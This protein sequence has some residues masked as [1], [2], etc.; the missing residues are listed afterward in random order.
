MGCKFR[1]E[2][3]KDKKTGEIIEINVPIYADINIKG[4]RITYSTGYRVD[5]SKWV[6]SKLKDDKTGEVV[7][8]QC[9]LPKSYGTRSG[10][11]VAA[12]IINADLEIIR[13]TV[14]NIIKTT[15]IEKI[16]AKL[17]ISEI[18]EQISK[19]KNN[20]SLEGEDSSFWGLFDKFIETN[21]V[22]EDR[23]RTYRNAYS[24]LRNFEKYSWR[25][26]ID[27]ADCTGAMMEAFDMFMQTD[28]NLNGRYDHLPVRQRPKAKSN[29]T[30]I[31]IMRVLSAFFKWLQRHHSITITA[32]NEYSIG[33]EVYEDPYFLTIDERDK[34]LALELTDAKLQVAQDI[35]KFQTFMGARISDLYDLRRDNITADGYIEFIADKTIIENPRTIRIPMRKEVK[36]VIEKYKDLPEDRLFPY[37]DKQTYN[38]LLRE[39][40]VKAGIMRKVSI[41]DKLTMK[42]EKKYIWEVF[43]SHK[44]RKTFIAACK[45]KGIPNSTIASMSGH[46]PNSK[47]FNRYFTVM[48]EQK[49][50]ALDMI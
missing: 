42:E 35:F 32:F 2:K 4:L 5:S 47:A 21:G 46:Q 29:N 1:I 14:A 3:R 13:A 25:R 15:P 24:N 34:I 17:V 26:K 39:L 50:E 10:I 44:V 43:S 30:R 11:R 23:K 12:H 7:H 19:L 45:R 22:S 6:N 9:V 16:T 37:L 20:V 49:V 28:N 33:S 38:E 48:D 36:E 41:L 27:F 40:I 8:K 18:D 31:K